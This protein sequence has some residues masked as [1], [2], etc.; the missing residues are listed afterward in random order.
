MGTSGGPRGD[1]AVGEGPCGDMKEAHGHGG[2]SVRGREEHC[3]HGDMVGFPEGIWRCGGSLCGT[4]VGPCGD[5][6][7]LESQ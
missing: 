6:D 4:N 3:G 2:E 1:M 5:G 7:V